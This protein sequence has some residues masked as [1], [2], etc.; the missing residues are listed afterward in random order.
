LSYDDTRGAT[1]FFPG[2]ILLKRYAP[3]IPRSRMF[4]T[5]DAT[6]MRFM[7]ILEQSPGKIASTEQRCIVR[8]ASARLAS[9]SHQG[10]SKK[11]ISAT[12]RDCG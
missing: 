5:S 4:S 9:D 2:S 3:A 11:S 6:R 8:K 1:T 10:R 12:C 7:V